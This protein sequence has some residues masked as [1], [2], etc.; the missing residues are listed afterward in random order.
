MQDSD[1]L[2][3]LKE[4]SKPEFLKLFGFQVIVE[5]TCLQI[6]WFLKVTAKYFII[7]S[8]EIK[9][10]REFSKGDKNQLYHLVT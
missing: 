1:M 8:Q 7:H 9:T 2:V 5:V 4:R 6:N 10:S 3:E